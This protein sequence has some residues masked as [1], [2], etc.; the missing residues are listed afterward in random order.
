M[1]RIEKASSETAEALEEG[2]ISSQDYAEQTVAEVRQLVA[3]TP[4]P[5]RPP[6]AAEAKPPSHRATALEDR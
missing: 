1:T 4:L 6:H 3:T 5:E 2:R